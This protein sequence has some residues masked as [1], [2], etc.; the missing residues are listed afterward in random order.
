[1]DFSL[2]HNPDVI[3]ALKEGFIFTLTVT[4]LA[5]MGGILIGTPLAMMRLSNNA[6]ASNFA[7]FYVDLFRGIPLIQVIFIFYFLLP[8][9]FEFQSD[10]YWGPLFSSVV[11]FAIFEAAFFSEIVR[12][13]IQ[14]I[15]KGQVNAGY[16]LGFTYG[17]SM[18]YVVL[19]QAFRNMLP[20]LLTQTIILFQDVSLVYVISAPD[21][22]GRADTLANTY[23][24]E[25]KATFYLIVA[26]VYF[27]SSFVLSQLV[28]RLQKKIAIIR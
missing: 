15:S 2:L 5:M 9:I 10:T 26:V 3:A 18:R 25:T 23:G 8:K 4:V 20:V 12:S 1:M 6:L 13:G 7:K 14:S 11:T 21:F 28:K 17:Q 19:P 22:L 24:P 16:T 27:C